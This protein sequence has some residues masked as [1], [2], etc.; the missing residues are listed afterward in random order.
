MKDESNSVFEALGKMLGYSYYVLT[1]FIDLIMI[2]IGAGLSLGIISNG[3]EGL[4]SLSLAIIAIS[5]VFCGS[6]ILISKRKDN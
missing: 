1:S 2:F 4:Q 3:A 6:W 5:L